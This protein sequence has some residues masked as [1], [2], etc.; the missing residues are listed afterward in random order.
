MIVESLGNQQ[1]TVRLDGSGRITLRNRRFLREIQPLV[2]YSNNVSDIQV[3][4]VPE[5]SKTVEQVPMANVPEV[6]NEESNVSQ[7]VRKSSRIRKAPD[8]YEA[9]W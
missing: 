8:R 2:Q 1:Y 9:N 7:G 3:N 5:P 4:S 6:I